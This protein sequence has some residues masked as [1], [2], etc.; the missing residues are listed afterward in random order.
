M[1]GYCSLKNTDPRLDQHKRGCQVSDDTEKIIWS[2]CEMEKI[3]RREESLICCA[4]EEK[5]GSV[6]IVRAHHHV[7]V[8]A[9]VFM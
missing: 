2:R 7:I 8:E 4:H 9:E 3:E 1:A 5:N 6:G